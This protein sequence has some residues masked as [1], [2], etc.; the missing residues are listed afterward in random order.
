M[1]GAG[2][3]LGW[4]SAR[5]ARARATPPLRVEAE[6][7]PVER[8]QPEVTFALRVGLGLP[9]DQRVSWMAAE[10]RGSGGK[11][12]GLAHHLETRQFRRL[13]ADQVER[14]L[15]PKRDAPTPRPV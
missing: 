4:A 7:D 8:P 2:S 9:I 12:R 11:G 15:T 3:L 5:R 10:R 13:G 6:A 1:G 14:H